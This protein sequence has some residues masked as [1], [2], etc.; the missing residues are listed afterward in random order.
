M[1]FMCAPRAARR[2]LPGTRRAPGV[3]GDHLGTAWI[4]SAI[5][6][7]QGATPVTC[8][9]AVCVGTVRESPAERLDVD[10]VALDPPNDLRPPLPEDLGHGGDVS[11]LRLEQTGQLLSVP[12][13]GRAELTGGCRLGSLEDRPRQVGDVDGPGAAQGQGTGQ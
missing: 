1:R 7:D 4:A 13:L 10:A 6:P 9:R 5:R 12:G 2:S 11:S 3:P 8:D